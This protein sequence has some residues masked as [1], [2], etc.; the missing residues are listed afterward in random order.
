MELID[1]FV[2][3]LW[4]GLGFFAGCIHTGEHKEQK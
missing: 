4:F 1:I 3:I 2:A